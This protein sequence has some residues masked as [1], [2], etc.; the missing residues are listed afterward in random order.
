MRE[1]LCRLILFVALGFP[2]GVL[3][4]QNGFQHSGLRLRPK[5]TQSEKIKAQ[6]EFAANFPLIAQRRELHPRHYEFPSANKMPLVVDYTPSRPGI[7]AA[8]PATTQIWAN[9]GFKQGWSEEDY[10]PFGYYSFTPTDVEYKLLYETL[11]ENPAKNGVQYKDGHIYGVDLLHSYGYYYETLYDTD[12]K[13]GETTSETLDPSTYLTLAATETAQSWD[14]T[15]Y[16]QF[17]SADGKSFEWG[18]VDYSTKTRTTIGASTHTFVALGITHAGQLYGVATDGNLYKIDKADGVETLVGPT[19]LTVQDSLGYYGQTGEINQADDTFYWAAIQSNGKGGIYI[20]DLETGAAT[21]IG[22][23]NDEL[24]GMI[25]PEAEAEDDAPGR[26]TDGTLVFRAADLKGQVRFT[27]PTKTFAGDPLSGELNYTVKADGQT[28]ATGKTTAGASVA[29][30]VVVPKSGSYTFVITTSNAVGESPKAE[31]TGWIGFDVPKPVT[32]IK[33]SKTD[34]QVTVSWAEPTTGT[35]NHLLGELTYDVFRLVRGDTTQIASDITE[36]SFTD[37]LSAEGLAYYTYLIRAKSDGMPGELAKSPGMIVGDAI[38]P[39]WKEDFASHDEFMLFTIVDA[40]NDRDTWRFFPSSV[41]GYSAQSNFNRR[42]G[43]DD[44]MFTPPIH[45]TPGRLYTISFRARNNSD[46]YPNSLEV[47]WGTDTTA[48]AMT[49]TLLA[50]T[51]PSSKWKTYSYE[52]TAPEDGNYYIGFHDNTEEPDQM[53]VFVD[54]IVVEK[55]ALFTSPQAV[56]DVTIEAADKGRLSADITFKIPTASVN[57]D[58]I[59]QVD[60]VQIARDGNHIATLGSYTAGSTARYTDAEVPTNGVHQYEITTYLNQEYGQKATASAYIGQDVPSEPKNIVLH[61]NQ[62]NVRVEWDAFG[63]VGPYGRYVDPSHVSVSFYSLVEGRYRNTVGDSITTSAPGVTSMTL[64][65]DPEESITEDGN[66][67]ALYHLAARANGDAGRSG[68]VE[69]G[70]LV[71]GPSARL[72]FKESLRNGKL[73][74]GFAWVESNDQFNNNEYA[75]G[76]RIMTDNS[77]DGDGGSLLWAPYSEELY[78]WSED[79]TIKAGDETSVNMPKVSLGGSTNPKLYFNL[80]TIERDSATLTVL[81]QTPDGVDHELKTIDLLAMPKTGW[82]LQEAD[83]T[84]FISQR[85]VIIK[86]RGTALG[87]NVHVGIDNINI[88]DQLEYNL[89]AAGIKAPSYIRAGKTGKVDAYVENFGAHPTK[90]YSVVLYVNGEPVDTIT[91]DKELGILEYDT[92]SFSLPV[93]INKAESLRVRAEVVYD[94]DLDE[95]DNSTENKTI[96]IRPSEYTT[97]K[98]LTATGGDASVNLSWSRPATP[99]PIKV[100]EDFEDYDAFATEFGDWKLVDGDEG[101]AATLFNGINYPGEGTQFAFSIF[102]PESLQEGILEYNPGL[103]PHSGKQFAAAPY[104]QDASGSKLVEPSNWIISP[105]LPGDKQTVSFYAYNVAVRD[106]EGNT[107]VYPENFDV[108]YSVN[109]NDTTSFVKLESDVADGRTDFSEGSNWREFNVELPEGAKYF[110]IHHNSS[111]A[112]NFIF[113]L[114]DISFTAQAPGANDSITGYRVYRDGVLIGSVRDGVLSFADHDAGAGS[115]V[116]NVTVTYLSADGETNE[117]G[118]S[119]DATLVVA[120]GIDAIAGDSNGLYNVYTLDGQVVA[121][122]AR[123]LKGLK[124]GL[125]IINDRKYIIK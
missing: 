61:D 38:E 117:S 95:E 21:K 50:T 58:P 78:Y 10:G 32:G 85:Y 68:F 124:R 30:S 33:L 28:L 106:D 115:H 67:Q 7:L 88:F 97:V 70:T 114:D 1:K 69:T 74:N 17:Y 89:A 52:V 31:V 45:L 80:N 79:Y 43:N 39:T 56:S 57:G 119:N 102:N 46:S 82:S 36:T 63:E 62:D 5:M 51:K 120:D 90:D 53:Y 41:Y 123:S 6:R 12:T 55:G 40:N 112:D 93:A 23:E 19:G 92:V 66:E 110:A 72:P 104:A 75:A 65:Q 109:G 125:Y 16:G 3:M 122:K 91:V 9:L 44:W 81:A 20:V 22:F 48:A 101:F 8:K 73:D 13:T 94:N 71:V 42:N 83:L 26:A 103:T 34:K 105:E 47:K 15:V 4:A 14:G 25:I 18:T 107:Q 11:A 87:A 111:G 86:F 118:F 29:A 116:Y 37:N 24:Y 2:T 108:L 59:S 100:R 54:D 121:L 96:K 98:D 113:G 64:N 76:W 77:Y 27:A 84:P 99:L 35:H 60:S 49:N